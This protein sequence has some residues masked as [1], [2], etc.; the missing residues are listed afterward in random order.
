MFERSSGGAEGPL[1]VEITFAHG[2]TVQGKL[3][4][5]QGRKLTDV[6]NGPAGFEPFGGERR[7]IAKAA[8]H[9]V[10]P[11]NVPAKPDLWAG[12]T[13]GAGFDP[14]AVLGLERGS[15][16]DKVRA[17]YVKLAKAYHPDRYTAVELPLEVRDYLAVMARRVNAAYQLLEASHRRQAEKEGPVFTNAGRR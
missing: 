9:C 1:S 12:A 5:P 11:M 6:L 3:L 2:Q 15:D 8:L 4:V 13:E 10:R 7:F 14:L 16:W 17:A